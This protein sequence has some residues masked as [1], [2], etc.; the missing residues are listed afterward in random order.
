L[1]SSVRA[2]GTPLPYIWTR[3]PDP[4]RRIEQPL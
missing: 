4:G 3:R 1:S 2:I